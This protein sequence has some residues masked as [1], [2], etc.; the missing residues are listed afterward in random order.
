M[1]QYCH[2]HP[3]SPAKWHC[4][5]CSRLY[6][7][8]CL[9]NANEK[10]LHGECPFCQ[11]PLSYLTT[12]NSTKNERYL[13]KHLIKDCLTTNNIYLLVISVGIAAISTLI[14]ISTTLKFL[15][16]FT[17]VLFIN[18]HFAR[19]LIYCEHEYQQTGRR[20]RFSRNKHKQSSEDIF[21][22]V[23]SVQLTLV[24]GLI[25]LFPI[26]CFYSLNWLIGFLLIL[27]A[28]GALP[29]LIIFSLHSSENDQGINLSMLF[30]ELK[31]YSLKLSLQSLSLFWLVLFISDF[32]LSLLPLLSAIAISAAMSALALFNVFRFF[33]QSCVLSF[34]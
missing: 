14:D 20:S 1:N 13:L 10:L 31:P 6:D 22:P 33:V 25:L 34:H 28:G 12:E 21:S 5:K 26:Y 3:I 32:A 16:C 9:P 19:K 24:M 2:F 15:V 8:A 29:F 30:K 27:I 23:A 18:L 11:S 4:S 17:S 7:N